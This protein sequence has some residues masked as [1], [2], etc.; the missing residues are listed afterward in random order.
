MGF[1]MTVFDLEAFISNPSVEQL[2]QCR[3]E[4][5]HAIAAYFEVALSKSFLKPELK[6][7]VLHLLVDRKVLSTDGGASVA[8]PLSSSS[9]L[10][11]VDRQ[12][13]KQEEDQVESSNLE[14]KPPRTVPKFT[15]LTVESRSTVDDRIKIR[16][17]RLQL[18]V[19][20]KER[21]AEYSHRLAI[22]KME[23]D[24]E[25]D[26]TNRRM[27]LELENAVK[28]KQLENELKI[29]QLE[30]EAIKAVNPAPHSDQ[31]MGSSTVVKGFEV[32]RNIALVPQFRKSE[33]DS[34]FS[35]FER[36]AT[37]LKWPVDVWAIMLQ[38]K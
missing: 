5:L 32:S 15:P 6:E 24:M 38:S 25:A 18:N 14:L 27:V 35:A 37:A 26:L 16:L 17:A 20:E 21:D 13:E 9:P 33:V 3:K 28:M 30:L 4:D 19:Q 34:Y 31:P 7:A 2:D 29:K 22:R 11:V 12:D 36:V 23:L 8:P 1:I 10:D